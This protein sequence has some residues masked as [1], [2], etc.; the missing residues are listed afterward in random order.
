LPSQQSLSPKKTTSIPP[1]TQA[2]DQLESNQSCKSQEKINK[3]FLK[4]LGYV[5]AKINQA[6][7]LLWSLKGEQEL[8]HTKGN[9]T[10][11]RITD[12]KK[13]EDK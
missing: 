11:S 2:E 6:S 5:Y 9:K 4:E 3:D 13:E 1:L 8:I 10:R 12:E 7:N